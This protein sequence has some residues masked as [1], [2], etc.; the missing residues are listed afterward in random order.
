MGGCVYVY[1]FICTA[2][3]LGCRVWPRGPGLYPRPA[4]SD[5]A[6]NVAVRRAPIVV[7]IRA[8]GVPLVADFRSSCVE[9]FYWSVCLETHEDR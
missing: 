4:T 2:H 7:D 8:L 6:R 5:P 3:G 9:F 1:T